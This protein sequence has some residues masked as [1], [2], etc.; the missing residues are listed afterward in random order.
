MSSVL[1]INRMEG[2]ITQAHPASLSPLARRSQ[3]TLPHVFF[4]FLIA[5]IGHINLQED[6]PQVPILCNGKYSS[7]I[8]WKVALSA[9]PCCGGHWSGTPEK[10]SRAL[11]S[12]PPSHGVLG[13]KC[14][15]SCGESWMGTLQEKKRKKKERKKPFCWQV[16]KHC[17]LTMAFL[18][19]HRDKHF[20]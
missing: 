15:L 16:T 1:Q 14:F 18:F 8:P 11:F 10:R 9:L 5:A 20:I 3:P 19:H 4:S 6:S 7:C 12:Q 13:V 17:W 2:D